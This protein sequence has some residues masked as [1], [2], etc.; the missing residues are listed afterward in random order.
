MD[1]DEFLHQFLNAWPAIRERLERDA[2]DAERYRWLRSK[3][4]FIGG[5]CN[6]S[7]PK[8]QASDMPTLDAAID[9]A[10]EREKP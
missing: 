5:V 6:P 8:L 1:N 7:W 10:R 2:E 9:A 4:Y 3:A